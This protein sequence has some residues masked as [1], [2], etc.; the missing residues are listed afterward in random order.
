MPSTLEPPPGESTELA[1]IV[2]VTAWLTTLV[3]GTGSSR[4]SIREQLR[5]NDTVDSVLRR[6]GERF[7][8]LGD[9]LWDRDTGEPGEHVEILV[10]DEFVGGGVTLRSKVA[11]SDR[12]TLIAQFMG[13]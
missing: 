10:N 2:E 8:A 12:I 11:A 9:A 4:I 3:G 1:V 5:A 7:P 6:V 13:G